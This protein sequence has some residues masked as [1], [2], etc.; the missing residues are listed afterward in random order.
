MS[1]ETLRL[2]QAI[3]AARLAQVSDADIQTAKAVL[4]EE[5]EKVKASKALSEAMDRSEA[6]AGHLDELVDAIVRARMLL[7]SSSNS[8]DAD[9]AEKLWKRLEELRRSWAFGLT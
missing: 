2:Q 3:E 5:G 8:V 9:A 6:S 7:V 1:P 4:E